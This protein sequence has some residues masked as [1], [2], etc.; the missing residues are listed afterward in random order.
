MFTCQVCALHC[1]FFKTIIQ[2]RTCSMLYTRWGMP[3][4][5]FSKRP[6]QFETRKRNEFLI[7]ACHGVRWCVRRGLVFVFRRAAPGSMLQLVVPKMTLCVTFG[8]LRLGTHFRMLLRC[9]TYAMICM[10]WRTL[11]PQT[12]L[13]VA[14]GARRR[15][16][17]LG[18]LRG[19]LASEQTRPTKNS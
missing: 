8:A 18:L 17:P 14:F 2:K 12:K 1:L 10:V 5:Y 15:W 6:L 3:L 19:R 7:F 13:C 11:V 4:V 9:A 16:V